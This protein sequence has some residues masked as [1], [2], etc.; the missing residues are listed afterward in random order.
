MF[1]SSASY[2]SGS[3]ERKCH[4]NMLSFTTRTRPVKVSYLKDSHENLTVNV[5]DRQREAAYCT[6]DKKDAE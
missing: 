4:M 1:F 3:L 5:L 6:G 2:F